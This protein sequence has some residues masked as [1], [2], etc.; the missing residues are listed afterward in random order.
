V[1]EFERAEGIPFE[2]A[3]P[4]ADAERLQEDLKAQIFIAKLKSVIRGRFW[5]VRE[6]IGHRGPLGSEV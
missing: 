1:L 6:K 2:M 4:I 3:L 5:L